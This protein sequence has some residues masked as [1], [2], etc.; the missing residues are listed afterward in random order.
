[1]CQRQL[2][3]F[4]D[5]IGAL[6]LLRKVGEAAYDERINGTASDVE[7]GCAGLHITAQPDVSVKY[8]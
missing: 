3:V 8:I 6:R 7:G 4:E 5:R 2:N 1:M